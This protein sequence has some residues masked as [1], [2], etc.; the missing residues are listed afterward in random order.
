MGV[1]TCKLIEDIE[2]LQMAFPNA[3]MSEEMFNNIKSSEVM[4]FY[5]Y[6]QLLELKDMRRDAR[7]N[8]EAPDGKDWQ[9]LMNE[10]IAECKSGEK[11]LG[12]VSSDNNFQNVVKRNMLLIEETLGFPPREDFFKKY[13]EEVERIIN[14]AIGRNQ[15][16]GSEMEES[17]VEYGNVELARIYNQ[18]ET[19]LRKD[20]ENT[21]K[22]PL[23]NLQEQEVTMHVDH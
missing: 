12:L 4:L 20:V 22:T 7:L 9:S 15:E 23:T 2:K 11:L 13:D 18:G 6:V 17:V 14:V 5:R 1:N 16:A 21:A 10:K 19:E 3:K 8:R